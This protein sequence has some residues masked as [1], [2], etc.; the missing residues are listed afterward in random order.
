LK[1]T[2]GDSA[3]WMLRGWGALTRLRTQRTGFAPVP[4]PNPFAQTPP[5]SSGQLGDLGG[6]AP[7]LVLGKPFRQVAPYRLVLIKH[8][9]G[10][11]N[12]F[13]RN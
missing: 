9:V 1:A 2:M 5:G 11:F 4:T 8:L 12:Q 10:R 7:R 13:E 3:G 6:D